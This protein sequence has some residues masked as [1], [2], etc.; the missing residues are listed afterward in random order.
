MRIN[1]TRTCTR[2]NVAK[3]PS[4]FN[5]DK[6]VCKLCRKDV[7]Q[8]TPRPRFSSELDEIHANNMP[9]VRNLSQEEIARLN[10][11]YQPPLGKVKRIYVDAVG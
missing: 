2:C 1:A 5:G 10:V 7:K 9:P 6:T 4:A 8:R 11:Q 3:P